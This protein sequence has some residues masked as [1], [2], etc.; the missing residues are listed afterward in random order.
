MIVI[1]K[2]ISED[3]VLTILHNDHPWCCIYIPNIRTVFK[4][5]FK[6]LNFFSWFS[7]RVSC[8]LMLQLFAHFKPFITFCPPVEWS[9]TSRAE[10][11]ENLTSI[12]LV[13]LQSSPKR[14]LKFYFFSPCNL[15]YTG[16]P[17]SFSSLLFQSNNF[18]QT[19]NCCNLTIS[20]ILGPKLILI[21][22]FL[23]ISLWWMIRIWKDHSMHDIYTNC[24]SNFYDSDF[25]TRMQ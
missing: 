21:L 12:E 9:R 7:H 18:N 10:W 8:T 15:K 24:K 5:L 13:L 2:R 6:K 22:H 16:L 20:Q 1:K 3:Y 17:K 19:A 23:V 4:Y 11:K 14:N 25:T